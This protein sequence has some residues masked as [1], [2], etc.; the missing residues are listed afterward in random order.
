MKMRNVPLKAFAKKSPTKFIGDEPKDW[1]PKGTKG[2]IGS[3]IADAVSPKNLLEVIPV[4][5][6]GKGIK[7]VYNLFKGKKDA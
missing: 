1:S 6:L 4:G 2:N 7:T 3:K 5:K